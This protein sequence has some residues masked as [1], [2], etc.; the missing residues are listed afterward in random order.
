MCRFAN[1][2]DKFS[3]G[4]LDPVKE[5]SDGDG[6]ADGAEDINHNGWLD[7]G[8]TDPTTSDTDSDDISDYAET[9]LDLDRDGFPDI[10]K[11]LLRN[12][13]KCSPPMEESDLDCDGVINARDDDSDGDGCLDRDE[14]MYADNDTNGIPDVWEQV[15]AS[16]GTNSGGGL[17]GGGAPPQTPAEKPAPAISY[18][19][20]EGGANC[21]LVDGRGNVYDNLLS[22]IFIALPFAVL[23]LLISTRISAL[24]HRD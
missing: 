1:G 23:R 15:Q 13:A 14:G 22:L 11:E 9:M 21:S 6:L 19:V 7:I 4:I 5:D 17:S 12:G 2:R 24:P 3:I 20:D 16:C 18:P 10:V 8:E